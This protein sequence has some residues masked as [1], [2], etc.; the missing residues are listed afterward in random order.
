M[1]LRGGSRLERPE[2]TAFPGLRIDL[3]RVQ[4]V[5]ARWEFSNH[6]LQDPYCSAWTSWS[7][8]PKNPPLQV[9]KALWH[10]DALAAIFILQ[11]Q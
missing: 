11:F 1:L 9:D 2:I 7:L 3:A 10:D 6:A 4:P 5:F 8:P